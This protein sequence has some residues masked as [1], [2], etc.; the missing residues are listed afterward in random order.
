M[1]SY[2]FATLEADQ[3]NLY[4]QPFLLCFACTAS[5]SPGEEWQVKTKV[6]HHSSGGSFK[7]TP[8]RLTVPST[9][10]PTHIAQVK[11]TYNDRVR[12]EHAAI[13]V[14]AATLKALTG[15]VFGEVTQVGERGDYWLVDDKGIPAGLLEVSG[16]MRKSIRNRYRA[17]RK[18][19]LKNKLAGSSFVSVTRFGSPTG[20]YFSRVR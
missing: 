15:Y 2:D 16:T 13:A 8:T 6:R 1:I 7:N 12:S 4:T 10:S 11:K 20:G 14:A 19:V 18:Q 17:K 5:C 3:P 9:L